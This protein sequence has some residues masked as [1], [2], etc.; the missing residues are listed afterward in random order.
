MVPQLF[1][2][3]HVHEYTLATRFRSATIHRESGF[4]EG[5]CSLYFCAIES[6]KSAAPVDA[7]SGRVAVL[8]PIPGE[9]I[10]QPES[11]TLSIIRLRRPVAVWSCDGEKLKTIEIPIRCSIPKRAPNRF[12]I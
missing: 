11:P 4:V 9:T 6:Q 5:A 7:V 2:A 12:P 10:D 3:L 8:G 1:A